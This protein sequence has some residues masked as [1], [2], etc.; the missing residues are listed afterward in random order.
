MSSLESLGGWPSLL[1]R[2]TRA[3]D[4]SAEEAEAALGSILSGEAS[5][6]HVAAFAAAM[7]TK[8]ETAGELVGLVRAM[9]SHAVRLDLGG[10]LVDTCGTGGDR[11]GT[12]NVSTMA[13]VVVASSGA[14]VVK[15]GGR[16]SSSVSGSADVFEALGVAIDL[17]PDGVERCVKEVG[18]GFCFAPRFHPAMRHAAPVRRELGVP[19]VFNFLGPLANP[20]GA[21]R[22]LIGVGDARMAPL[23]VEVLEEN[24]TEHAMVVHG[25]DGLDEL[26]TT[27]P[28]HVIETRGGPSGYER[29]EFDL[30]PGELGIDLA[31]PGDLL[32]GSP[33]ENAAVVR[34]VFSGE[35]GPKRDFALL[36]AAA[37]LVVAGRCATFED[38]LELASC[39]VDE[40][41][42]LATLER[43]AAISSEL[44]AD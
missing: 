37:G 28:S 10:G 31:A 15:H 24:G 1:G 22:Q 34:S 39:L 33:A 19:T 21:T 26:T 2:L 5:P 41:A 17:G 18:I 27:A 11:S 35:K 6:V 16:A 44:E 25:Q 42:A 36:N 43:L 8:G 23:M 7:R 12:I 29:R 32:G 40:G 20:A 14:R 4:L 3:H 9:R 13:A 38:G 30:D